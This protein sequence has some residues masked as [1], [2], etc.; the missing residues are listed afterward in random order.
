MIKVALAGMFG[1][2]LRTALTALA[3]VLGVAM[4]SGTLTLTGSIDNAF[5]Y[6]FTSVRQG[7]DAVV[8][9]KAAVDVSQGQG[10]FAPTV[11]TALLD[12]VRKLPA[13]SVRGGNLTGPATLIGHDGKAVTFGGAPNLGFSIQNGDS[14]FNPL[15]L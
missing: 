4:V 15:V 6:I 7:S 14:P 2:K 1:R 12:R 5:N 9:G 11:P 8:T 3:I 10:S 13:V